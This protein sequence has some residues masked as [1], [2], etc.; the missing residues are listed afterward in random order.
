M[1]VEEAIAI[2]TLDGAYATFEEKNKGS[3]VSGK[4]A[5]FVVLI[6][7]RASESGWDQRNCVDATYISGERVWQAGPST[8]AS[9]ALLPGTSFGDGD[10]WEDLAQP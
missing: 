8:T 3:I 6:R 7:T 4:L 10:E 5:D 2:W 9:R 1:S